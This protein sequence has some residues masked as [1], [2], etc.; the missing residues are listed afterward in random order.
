MIHIS[1]EGRLGG[2]PTPHESYGNVTNFNVAVSQGKDRDDDWYKCSAWNELADK[3]RKWFKTGSAIIVHGRLV[4][5]SWE[6]DGDTYND[7][8][9]KV[10]SFDFPLSRGK[11]KEEEDVDVIQ[12]EIV[13]ANEE[14]TVAHYPETPGN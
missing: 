5:T 12:P 4:R 7:V 10:D 9:V 11:K 6:K 13:E 2:D 8:E 14:T 1:L 3:I